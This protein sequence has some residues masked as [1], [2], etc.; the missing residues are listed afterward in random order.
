MN[1]SGRV[2]LNVASPQSRLHVAT[3]NH[4]TGNVS[5]R[6]TTQANQI[7]V[8]TREWANVCATFESSIWV[9]SAFVLLS[10]DSRIKK[11]V[12]ELDDGECLNKLLAL[13]PVKYSYIDNTRNI[14]GKKVYGFIA[15]D[16]KEVLPEMIRINDD[17]IPNIYKIAS[18]H[19]ENKII[20]IDFEY[21]IIVG[22]KL[23]IYQDYIDNFTDCI[24]TEKLNDTSFKIDK[25]LEKEAIF[26]YGSQVEDFH[27]MDKNYFHALTVSSCQELHRKIVSQQAEIDELKT[28]V[29]M[30]M[31]HLNL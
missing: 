14:E 27:R 23:R 1:G 11:D 6:W 29:N 31:T 26:I 30:L 18:Y 9:K 10:S 2:G 7:A 19:I 15:Q 25:E 5:M 13:K 21:N 28:K 3:D 8:T 4:F 16:V 22:T 12:E 20:N 24:I 17:Y